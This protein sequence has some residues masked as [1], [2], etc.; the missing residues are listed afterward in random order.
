MGKEVKLTKASK[1]NL[2]PRCKRSGFV[3]ERGEFKPA[4]RCQACGS[5][6][7]YGYDGGPYFVNALNVGTTA[8]QD[9]VEHPDLA[10][11]RPRAALE[12]NR[13]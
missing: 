11:S 3:L 7:C 4:F 8:P 1:C 12:A 5:S 6:W 13:E 2:C 10:R 9:W